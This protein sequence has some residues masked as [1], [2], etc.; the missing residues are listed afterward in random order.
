MYILL[1]SC[2][3]LPWHPLVICFFQGGFRLTKPPACI[4]ANTSRSHQFT[5]GKQLKVLNKNIGGLQ[6]SREQEYQA[7]Y[8]GMNFQGK[9][10]C[11]FSFPGS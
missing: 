8:N 2:W 9:M 5:F 1:S 3:S 7:I 4:A 11:I 6:R 10:K